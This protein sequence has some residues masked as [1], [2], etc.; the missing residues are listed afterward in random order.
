MEKNGNG[1]D[2]VLTPIQG[3]TP[4][5]LKHVVRDFPGDPVAK[6]SCS[7]SERLGLGP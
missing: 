2:S 6:A 5:G 7:Q 3:W 1:K 4:D